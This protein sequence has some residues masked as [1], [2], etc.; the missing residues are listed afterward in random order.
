MGQLLINHFLLGWVAFFLN[1]LLS[2]LNI[3]IT[4]LFLLLA[5]VFLIITF[6]NDHFTFCNL[7]DH[8]NSIWIVNNDSSFGQSGPTFDLFYL[9]SKFL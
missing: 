5:I 4:F 9:L 3:Q 6:F 7:L 1:L 8:F 2:P